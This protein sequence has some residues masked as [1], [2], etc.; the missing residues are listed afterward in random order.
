MCLLKKIQKVVDII[1]R[2]RS[3]NIAYS[4]VALVHHSLK[5]N[6][7]RIMVKGGEKSLFNL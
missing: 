6:N 1:G 7:N 4:V 5:K 3:N 2:E